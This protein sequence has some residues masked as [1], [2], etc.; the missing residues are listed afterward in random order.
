MSQG[1][2]IALEGSGNPSMALAL[3]RLRKHF[4]KTPGGLGMS[5]WDASGIFFDIL[6]GPRGLPGATPRTLLLLYAADLAFRLRWEIE[7]ALAQGMTVI[8]AP[9]VETA[10]A[11]GKATGLPRAWVKSVFAFAPRADQLYRVPDVRTKTA[12]P[13]KA[14]DSFL[15]FSFLQLR[16]SSGR[17]ATDEA[18]TAF[19]EHLSKLESR[20]LCA[21]ATDQALAA[22]S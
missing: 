8:A 18:R 19:L 15:E 21:V 4:R 7:P 2:L 13:G 17:W 22:G 9:Y 11:F 16:R 3:K 10:F 5:H 14:A 12:Q 1:K 6:E 20:G